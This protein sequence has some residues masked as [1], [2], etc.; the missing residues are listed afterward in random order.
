M[1]QVL[2]RQKR[3]KSYIYLGIDVVNAKH[4]VPTITV[5]DDKPIQLSATYIDAGTYDQA[6]NIIDAGFYNTISWDTTW[7]GGYP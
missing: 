6:G 2:A 3:P 7:D 5:Y 1:P 4:S